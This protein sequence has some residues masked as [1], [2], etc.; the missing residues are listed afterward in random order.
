[1][2]TTRELGLV[3]LEGANSPWKLHARTLPSSCIAAKESLVV[4]MLTTR[5][6]G[7]VTLN[8]ELSKM[9]TPELPHWLTEPSSCTAANA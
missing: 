1:M 7:L 3:T 6:L 8:G 2:L 9:V 5:E 4:A